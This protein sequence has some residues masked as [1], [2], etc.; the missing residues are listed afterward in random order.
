MR[1]WGRTWGVLV[2]DFYAGYNRMAGQHQRCWAHLPR[3]LQ[4]LK[5]EPPDTPE[6]SAWAGQ[7]HALYQRA[8]EYSATHTEATL[9]EW[10]IQQ[11]AYEQDLLV[12]VQPGLASDGPSRVLCKRI[13]PFLPE[14]FTFVVD[15]RVPADNNAAERAIPPLALAR[16]ISGGTRSDEGTPVKSTL[17]TLF[18]T[19][20]AQGINP[21]QKCLALLYPP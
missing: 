16:K 6:V 18:G 21:F 3:D 10:V 17:A 1:C 9:R 7:V 13:A 15:P 11:H 8:K 12:L 20:V 4:A 2:S 5:E 14:L 19:W